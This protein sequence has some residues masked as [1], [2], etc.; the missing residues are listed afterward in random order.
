MTYVLRAP[1]VYSGGP[2][3]IRILF[4]AVGRLNELDES[5]MFAI[6]FSKFKDGIE[7]A[8]PDFVVARDAGKMVANLNRMPVMVVDGVAIGQIPVIKRLVAKR[9][10][11]MG[12]NDLEA[13][14][15][16]MVLEHLQDVKKEYND[17]KKVGAEAVAEWFTKNLPVWMGKL[18]NCLPGNNLPGNKISLPG[19]NHP[20]F[21]IGSK[22]SLADTELYT[23][24]TAFFDNLE[25]AAAS[26]AACPKI[27]KS[28]ELV[29]ALPGIVALREL[30]SST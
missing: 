1:N 29:K 23:I 21:L 9:M 6:D 25:G 22:L 7:V 11:L 16:E 15:M 4:A 24:V 19:N 3:H 12:D 10:G 8:C 26:I 5:E 17:T 30:A 13:A 2:L 18:E 20:G 27:Q 14:Q 28:V